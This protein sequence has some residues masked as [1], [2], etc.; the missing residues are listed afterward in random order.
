MILIKQQW[1]NDGNKLLLIVADA[2]VLFQ[3]VL[4]VILCAFVSVS[5]RER[6]TCAQI[7]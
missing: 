3:Q 5:M 2:G 6:E 4:A 7:N 1:D